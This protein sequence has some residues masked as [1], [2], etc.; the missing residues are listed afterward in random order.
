MYK[1]VCPFTI[2]IGS[3]QI[4][5]F[6]IIYILISF[7]LSLIGCTHSSVSSHEGFPLWDCWT[8]ESSCWSSHGHRSYSSALSPKALSSC[9]TGSARFIFLLPQP[10]SLTRPA[11]KNR[12]TALTSNLQ[13]LCLRNGKCTSVCQSKMPWSVGF[14]KLPRRSPFVLKHSYCSYLTDMVHCY[15]FWPSIFR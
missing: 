2:T 9:P 11:V 10:D 14:P 4:M 6:S 1:S 15:M 7:P 13:I 3:T 5:P 8:S 12:E